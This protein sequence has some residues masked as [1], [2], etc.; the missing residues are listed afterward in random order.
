LRKRD[1]VRWHPEEFERLGYASAGQ[2]C[3]GN[4]LPLIGI[5]LA[6]LDASGFQFA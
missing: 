4:V 1:T 2:S 3:R 6:T 5:A